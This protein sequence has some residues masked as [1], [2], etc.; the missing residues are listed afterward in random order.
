MYMY[1]EYI[2]VHVNVLCREFVSTVQLLE[3]H[4]DTAMAEIYGVEHLLRLFGGLS[5]VHYCV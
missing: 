4:P 5:V 2:F 3:T 1:H